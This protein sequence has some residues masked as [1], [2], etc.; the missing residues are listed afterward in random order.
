[1][2][3]QLNRL[4]QTQLY[5]L[6]KWAEANASKTTTMTI[7]ECALAAQAAVGFPVTVQ[8]LYNIESVTG[9]KI[10]RKMDTLQRGVISHA[11]HD[12]L[13]ARCKRLESQMAALIEFVSDFIQEI[14]GVDAALAFEAFCEGANA[15]SN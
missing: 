5:K 4:T 8:N 11:K 10:G 2:S 9:C 12:A 6:G 15:K 3:K 14:K 1:M 7:G 13:E